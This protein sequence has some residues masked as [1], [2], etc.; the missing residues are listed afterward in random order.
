MEEKS[1]LD[2]REAYERTPSEE[3]AIA[4]KTVIKRRKP[5]V[6]NL[7]NENLQKQREEQAPPLP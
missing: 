3:T 1:P 7:K 5:E 2:E 4:N 6:F